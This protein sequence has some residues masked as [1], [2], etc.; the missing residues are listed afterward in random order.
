MRGFARVIVILVAATTIAAAAATPVAAG[1]R[2]S[3]R[4]QPSHR[5]GHRFANL[6]LLWS[7]YPLRPRRE[8]SRARAIPRSRRPSSQASK[9]STRGRRRHHQ[10]SSLAWVVAVG[11]ATTVLLVLVARQRRRGLA[12]RKAEPQPSSRV[13]ADGGASEDG[14]TPAAD[15][16]EHSTGDRRAPRAPTDDRRIAVD[17]RH[18]DHLLF[19]PTS[20]GYRLVARP[21]DVPPVRFEFDGKDFG[22]DGR[23]RVSKIGA[24]PLPSDERECAYL[25]RT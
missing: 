25:E 12:L 19:V 14:I 23:F 20:T 2:H 1:A 11:V 18:D 17:W 16:G 4:P 13:A 10:G 5:T 21:G 8:S 3:S 24:S 15:W 9:A 22:L 7:A 6:K